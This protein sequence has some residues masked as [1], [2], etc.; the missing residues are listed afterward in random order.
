[1]PVTAASSVVVGSGGLARSAGYRMLE[2][3]LHGPFCARWKAGDWGMGLLMGNWI[4]PFASGSGK[5]GTPFARMHLA[6][7]ISSRRTF[8]GTG[9]ECPAWG[10]CLSH[11]LNARWP[12]GDWRLMPLFGLIGPSGKFGTPFARMHRAN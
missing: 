11:A 12:A 5:F 3:F 10:R 7:A 9:G 1:M 4:S 8:A 6:N 2:Y